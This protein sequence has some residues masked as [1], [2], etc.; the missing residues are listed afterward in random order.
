M[1]AK[2]WKTAARAAVILGD[3]ALEEAVTEVKRL[4][5]EGEVS[6]DVT[7][8]RTLGAIAATSRLRGLL[9]TAE[10]GRRVTAE[11][12]PLLRSPLGGELMKTFGHFFAATATANAAGSAGGSSTSIDP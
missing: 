2:A 6:A 5:R 9:I 1:K 7:F 11:L 10:V 4:Q 3:R 8:A 12:E